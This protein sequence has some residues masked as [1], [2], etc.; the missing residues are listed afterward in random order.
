MRQ[1]R[2]IGAALALSAGLAACGSPPDEQ[3]AGDATSE[4]AA[5]TGIA[6]PAATADGSP[7]AFAICKSC[8]T[9]EPGQNRIGPSLAGV[10]GRKSGSA[11]G[12]AYSE[13]MKASGLTWDRASLERWIEAPQ[14]MVPGTRMTFTGIK[15]AARRKEVID[16][17][18]TVK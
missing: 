8:H 18:E 13:A 10:F 14:Q 6:A 2:H 4:A 17:L 11:P 12:F 16:F 7:A 3:P 1:V 5:D 15:D 9:V